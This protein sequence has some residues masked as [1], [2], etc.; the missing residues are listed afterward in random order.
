MGARVYLPGL[1]RFLQVDLVE[2]GTLNNYVYAMDPVNQKDLN[3]EWLQLIAI[4][5]LIAGSVARAS[6]ELQNNPG[7]GMNWFN[8]GMATAG[9]SSFSSGL[10]A[11]Q[12]SG[13]RAAPQSILGTPSRST[14]TISRE[15]KETIDY[16]KQVKF[17]SPAP[18][19]AGGSVWRNDGG[20]FGQVLP[21]FSNGSEIKYYEW[22]VRPKVPGQSRGLERL[23]TGTD[24]SIWYTD[25][26]YL[27]FKRIE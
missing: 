27:T 22:D 26:H 13:A 3:G 15:A 7:D 20:N 24:G 23:V 10:R 2:G 16:L 25:D 12:S 14:A 5:V 4:G 18:N 9:V 21:R 17:S 6:K 1:G 8:M 19:T 11:L